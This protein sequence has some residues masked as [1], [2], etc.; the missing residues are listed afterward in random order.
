MHVVVEDYFIRVEDPRT[1]ML[2]N[3]FTTR[4]CGRCALRLTKA[5]MNWEPRTMCSSQWNLACSVGRDMNMNLYVAFCQGCAIKQQHAVLRS[6][7]RSSLIAN[8][9]PV[10]GSA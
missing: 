6:T 5:G 8:D 7:S 3:D 4:A 1:V 10:G 2:C 9:K